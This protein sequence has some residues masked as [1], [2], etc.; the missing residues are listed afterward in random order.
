MSKEKDI[1]MREEDP[2]WILETLQIYNPAYQF[3]DAVNIDPT[4]PTTLDLTADKLVKAWDTILKIFILI[5]S[6]FQT[7]YKKEFFARNQIIHS[8]LWDKFELNIHQILFNLMDKPWKG[9]TSH[10]FNRNHYSFEVI[11]YCLYPS[12]LL[13]SCHCP[14]NIILAVLGYTRDRKRVIYDI[15]ERLNEKNLSA[16]EIGILTQKL[17]FFSTFRGLSLDIRLEDNMGTIQA[18]SDSDLILMGEMR[19]EERGIKK[20]EIKIAIKLYRKG[21][22]TLASALELLNISESKFKEYLNNPDFA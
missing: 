18:I 12:E 7:A 22:I 1:S 9:K 14:F 5:H 4:L 13:L 21:E 15:M 16:E 19:G 17:N 6:E 2:N 3:Q 11:D 20:G 10:T 8:L